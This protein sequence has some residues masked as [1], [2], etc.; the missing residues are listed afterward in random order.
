MEPI[1]VVA[2]AVP[3]IAPAAAQ[4]RQSR[5]AAA[6]IRSTLTTSP[7]A[8]SRPTRCPRSSRITKRGSGLLRTLLVECAWCSLQYNRWSRQTY[9]RIH[10]GTQARKKKAAVAL[11]RKILVVA[12]AMLLGW[13]AFGEIPDAYTLGGS[14]LVICGGLYALHRER[15]LAQLDAAA[16][17][18]R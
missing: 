9:D 5:V 10:R 13:L 12:W 3:T 7:P 2:L 16:T 4:H 6:S 15:K 1:S 8:R 14:A 11:A 17:N 18:R